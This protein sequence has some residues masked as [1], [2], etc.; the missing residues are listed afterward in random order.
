MPRVKFDGEIDGSLWGWTVQSFTDPKT[1]YT[2][3]IDMAT[4]DTKCTCMDASCR[5][6]RHKPDVLGACKHARHVLKVAKRLNQA[7]RE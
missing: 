2:V 6:N 3:S 7:R 4:G 5:R 1:F